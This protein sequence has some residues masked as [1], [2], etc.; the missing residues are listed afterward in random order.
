M[1]FSDIKETTEVEKSEASKNKETIAKIIKDL[2][3]VFPKVQVDLYSSRKVQGSKKALTG[4]SYNP[5]YAVTSAAAVACKK[6]EDYLVTAFSKSGLVLNVTATPTSVLA[7]LSNIQI[8]VKLDDKTTR[9]LTFAWA[10]YAYHAKYAGVAL[11]LEY[12]GSKDE[13]IKN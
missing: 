4:F 9:T 7:S 8:K 11:W 13:K 10:K 12:L 2:N 1:R 3:L 6:V 5:D